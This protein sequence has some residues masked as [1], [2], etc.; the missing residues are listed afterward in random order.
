MGYF[1]INGYVVLP[2]VKKQ[3]TG[4]SELII[5]GGHN[6]GE[7][8]THSEFSVGKANEKQTAGSDGVILR[9]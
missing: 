8:K 5:K 3:N 4:R 6:K 2:P 9:R 7:E 1:V